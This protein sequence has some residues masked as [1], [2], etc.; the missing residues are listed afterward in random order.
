[1]QPFSLD[2]RHPDQDEYD[3]T[4]EAARNEIISKANAELNKFVERELPTIG[5]YFRDRWFALS[6]EGNDHLVR[7]E[8]PFGQWCRSNGYLNHDIADLALARSKY[9]EENQNQT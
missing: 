6:D 2:I 1:M 8:I 7:S 3:R 4:I 5:T 9:E